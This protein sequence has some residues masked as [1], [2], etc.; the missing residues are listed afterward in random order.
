MRNTPKVIH[1]LY[2]LRAH[3]KKTEVNLFVAWLIYSQVGVAVA[4]TVL[5]A[6]SQLCGFGDQD[7]HNLLIPY[8]LSWYSC[9]CKTLFF[10]SSEVYTC[11]CTY[12]VVLPS[13][14][15]LQHYAVVCC[16]SV[17]K[18]RQLLVLGIYYGLQA[19]VLYIHTCTHN[20]RRSGSPQTIHNK[21]G[22]PQTTIMPRG[23]GKIYPQISSGPCSIH[24][25]C[26]GLHF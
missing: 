16:V 11:T 6:T 8:W 10:K 25:V 23:H 5:K 9:C 19:H 26:Q 3:H 4:H 7:G 21:S 12:V 2:C 13:Q 18:T 17:S 14:L 24:L 1:L 20:M 22:S 15:S